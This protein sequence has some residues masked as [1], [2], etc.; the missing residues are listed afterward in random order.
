MKKLLFSLAASFL[1]IGLYTQKTPM[2]S[3]ASTS[4]HIVED[5]VINP[6]YSKVLNCG[7]YILVNQDITFKSSM[8]LGD[9]TSYNDYMS[10]ANVLTDYV[11]KVSVSEE[12]L[13]KVEAMLQEFDDYHGLTKNN[14]S[15]ITNISMVK[16]NTS[17]VFDHN[18]NDTMHHFEMF[19]APTNQNTD[20]T[21]AGGMTHLVNV[22]SP[23]TLDEIKARYTAYDEVDGDITSKLEFV[24]DYSLENLSPRP[25]YILASVTDEA[26]HTA[27]AADTI[28]VKDVSAPVTTLAQPEINIEVGTEYTLDDAKELFTFSDNF[29][30]GEDLHTYILDC[31]KD[32]YNTV[33]TYYVDG[34]CMD[35][36]GNYS[37]YVR[38]TINIVDTQ[39]PDVFLTTNSN[40]LVADHELTVDE[41]K[42]S[43]RVEDNYYTIPNTEIEIISNPCDG[44]EGFDFNLVIAVED[45]DGNRCE[46]TFLY[47]LSDTHAPIINVS[48]TIYIQEG[49]TLTNAQFLELL[50][51]VGAIPD[52]AT[53][54]TIDEEQTNQ[55][56]TTVSYTVTFND[57]TKQKNT[58]VLEYY[59]RH[60]SKSNN[61]LFL[62]LSL[63]V[64]TIL[65]IGCGLLAATKKKD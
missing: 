40:R 42:Q 47:Y 58:V 49:T 41:I 51:E 65:I 48:N 12:D 32:S 13:P 14:T 59:P 8:F 6:E 53:D 29:S 24:S 60:V 54:I 43:F 34:R 46:K 35:E 23:S 33:G 16:V 21:I 15:W 27:Y 36:A 17:A 3:S 4:Y 37:E 28:L 30:T 39:A 31:Y 7:Y 20:N 10:I 62:G 19:Y 61:N 45:P 18:S 25:Y 2:T 9:V 1:V 5:M 52:D 63:G 64:I 26:G 56:Q 44:T 11:K 50:K 57:G 22:D 38:L 55:N